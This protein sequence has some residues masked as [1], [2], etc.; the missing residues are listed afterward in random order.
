M[1]WDGSTW[2]IVAG[3]PNVGSGA[4]FLYGVDAR[5][6]NDVWAV[7]NDDL[8]DPTLIEHWNGSAWS[9]VPAHSGVGTLNAVA[10]DTEEGN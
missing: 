2:S 10:G 1:H 8:A 9:T 7:G 4:N 6:A 5:A 3:T